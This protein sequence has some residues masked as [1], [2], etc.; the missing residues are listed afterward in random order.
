[1][2]SPLRLFVIIFLSHAMGLKFKGLLPIVLGKHP[3][4]GG[5][6]LIRYGGFGARLQHGDTTV[7]FPEGKTPDSI[8]LAEAIALL[9]AA[10]PGSPHP[11][12]PG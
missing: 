2:T 12:A 3:E 6:V 1:M 11:A 8:T 4:T 10:A 9:E 5:L 7:E